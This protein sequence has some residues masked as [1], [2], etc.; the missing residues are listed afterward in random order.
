M[1]SDVS[2]VSPN[3]LDILQWSGT[4]W[5]PIAIGSLGQV[6]IYG[7]DGSIGVANRLVTLN[8]SAG[9][10]QFNRSSDVLQELHFANTSLT[11]S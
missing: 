4:V 7:A 5:T 1:L 11:I 10:L 6:N 9:N 2:N 8:G 3:S